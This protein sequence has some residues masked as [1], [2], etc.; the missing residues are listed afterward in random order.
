VREERP[1]LEMILARFFERALT[2]AVPM[3]ELATVSVTALLF[4]QVSQAEFTTRTVKCPPCVALSIAA[5]A[6]NMLIV[7]VGN[8][9][10]TTPVATA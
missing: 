1:V 2:A 4:R 5:V 3:M 6:I 8:M 7:S 9:F 10:W